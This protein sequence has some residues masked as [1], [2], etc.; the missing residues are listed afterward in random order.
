MKITVRK[1][2]GFAGFVG[3]PVHV[4]SARLG[5]AER[6]ELER[7][8]EEADVFSRPAALPGSAGADF[9]QYEL[10]VADDGRTHTVSFADD[11]SEEV[12]PLRRLATRVEE[13]GA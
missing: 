7:L 2:G 13:L 9:V 5:D 6:G 12:A 10:T 8:A 4:D 1:S 3:E 11:G